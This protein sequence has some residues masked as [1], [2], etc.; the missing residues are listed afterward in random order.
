MRAIFIIFRNSD[1]RYLA[2]VVREGLKRGHAVECWHD[3]DQPTGVKAY[4]FARLE[5]VPN[6]PDVGKPMT[7]VFHGKK[8]LKQKL[9][10]EKGIDVV[11]AS[12]IFHHVFP[13]TRLD[14]FSFE[15][16]TVMTGF[17]NLDE[18]T[19][20]HVPLPND[21][22]QMFF[23]HTEMML[24]EGKRFLAELKPEHAVHLD[25][26]CRDSRIVGTSEFDSFQDITNPQELRLRFKIPSGKNVLLYL[27]FAYSNLNQHSAW[28]RAFYGFYMS[29]KKTKDHVYL[30]H[31]RRNILE[32][33]LYKAWHLYKISGDQVARQ[34][35]L[36]GINIEKVFNAVRDFCDKNNLYLVV[37]PRLKNPLAEIVKKKADLIVWDDESRQNPPVLKEL[38]AISRLCISY[39]S[40]A[41]RAAAFAKVFTLN[42]RLP[43]IYYPDAISRFWY[44]DEEGSLF[45]FPGAVSNWSIEDVICDL[46]DAPLERFVVDSKARDQYIRNFIG[47]DDCSTSSRIFDILEDKMKAKS[48]KSSIKTYAQEGSGSGK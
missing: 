30:H 3:C 12:S 10:L 33:S 47:F 26:Q 25:A 36:K 46:R 31:Q 4:S 13:Q 32:N 43:E 39:S 37:K 17:D 14:I 9:I 42:I 23:V 8:D 21:R 19:R 16:A 28:E 35:F 5:N 15:W 29:T 7:R 48:E 20:V 24:K 6:F 18:M 40:S 11:F 34:Y 41:I 44:S 22:E 38:L 27:P 1:Y 2:P 45:N